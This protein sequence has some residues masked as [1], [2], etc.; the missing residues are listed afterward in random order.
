MLVAVSCVLF[1]VLFDCC[2]VFVGVR[3]VS[4]VVSC[5]LSTVC[6]SVGVVRCLVMAVWCCFE[7]AAMVVVGCCW[8]LCAV[9]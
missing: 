1:G 2:C 3:C 6:G 9:V 7:C 8:L 4:C 5:L